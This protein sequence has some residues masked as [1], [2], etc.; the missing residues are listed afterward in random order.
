MCACVHSGDP[1]AGATD[2]EKN[3]LIDAMPAIWYSSIK[4]IGWED[5]K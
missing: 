2:D 4:F 1:G 5:T 3:V